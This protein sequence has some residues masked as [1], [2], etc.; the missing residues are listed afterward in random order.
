MNDER[1]RQICTQRLAMW[2]DDLVGDHATPVLLLGI[3]HDDKK[4]SISICTNEEVE[5]GHLVGFLLYAVNQ[6]LDARKN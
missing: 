1:I 2:T 3:G 6:L 4:G 5:T